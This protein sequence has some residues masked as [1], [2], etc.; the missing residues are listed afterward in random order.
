MEM[1]KPTDGHAMLERLAGNWEGDEEMPPS[2]WDPAGGTA[3]ARMN[4]RMGLTGF[5]LI[6]DYEQERDGVIT[7]SGHSV[8]TYDPEE[9]LYSLHW[10]DSMGSPPERFTGRFDGDVIVMAHGG[11]MHARMTNDL[12]GG[13]LR[14]QM[15]MSQDGETWM[16]M[17]T[18]VY[19]RS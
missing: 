12:S 3:V 11:P 16:R 8:W 17:F 2:Q 15:E 13:E 4:N 7:Y 19:R 6:G 18:G 1:P 10:F 9:A 5:A 14:M